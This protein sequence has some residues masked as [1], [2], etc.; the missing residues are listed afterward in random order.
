MVAVATSVLF[1][2]ES[3]SAQRRQV[4][5]DRVVAVVGGSSILHS[6]LVEY[7]ENVIIR[8]SNP[9]IKH[10]LS[11]I[12]LNC[13]DKFKVRV[14]PSILEYNKRFGKYPETLMVRLGYFSGFS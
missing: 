12:A 8:F 4:M 9:Y 11:S 3:A 13:A 7:A 10:Y 5:L 1:V 14:M 6:E 2:A